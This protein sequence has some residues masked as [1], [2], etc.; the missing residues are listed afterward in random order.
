MVRRVVLGGGV[1]LVGPQEER[2]RGKRRGFS[3]GAAARHSQSARFHTDR[4]APIFWSYFRVQPGHVARVVILPGG[5]HAMWK[6]RHVPPQWS[7]RCHCFVAIDRAFCVCEST[8]FHEL[9]FVLT[10]SHG[11][12]VLD[13]V[14]FNLVSS[15]PWQFERFYNHV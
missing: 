3:P 1:P 6:H 11:T 5:F 2:A 12:S 7:C 10:F 8:P 14:G 15:V 9:S 13:F 4:F